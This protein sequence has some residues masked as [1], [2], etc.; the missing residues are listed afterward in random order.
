MDVTGTTSNTAATQASATAS[1]TKPALSSDFETFLRML[2]TQ[3]Q[4][5]DPLNP[6][7]STEFA[8]QLATFSSV[9]QQTRANELLTGMTAQLG[10]I[11]MTQIAGWVGMEART[12]GPVWVA[13][14][15]TVSLAP[16]PAT[17]ADRMAIVVRDEAGAKVGRM[18]MA[19]SDEPI[20]WV[21]TGH[22]GQPLRSGSYSFELESLNSGDVLTT[23]PLPTYTPIVEVRNE[24]GSTVLVLKGGVTANPADVSAL[25]QPVI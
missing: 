23:E 5:Q 15:N 7:E 24:D 8:T 3:M 10:I 11:G 21:P 12:D 13:G 4:N 14:G 6:M 19:A 2:T 17:A 20:D 9:E 16:A 22:D 18:E 1:S 25:R